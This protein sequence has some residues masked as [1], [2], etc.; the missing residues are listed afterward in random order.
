MPNL[1]TFS[2]LGDLQAAV[3]PQARRSLRFLAQHVLGLR[4]SDERCEALQLGDTPV[5]PAE[6]RAA[7]VFS[8]LAAGR[9]PEGLSPVE[10]FLV[11]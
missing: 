5:T 9:R 1:S 10:S 7:S 2:E 8:A 3:R 6:R 4:L 11:S